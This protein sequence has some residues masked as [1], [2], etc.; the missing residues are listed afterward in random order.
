MSFS[1]HRPVLWLAAG[2]VLLVAAVPGLAQPS[3]GFKEVRKNADTYVQ[4][5]VRMMK[6]GRGTASKDELDLIAQWL[7]FR[8]TYP[9]AY[10]EKDPA[11]ATPNANGVVIMPLTDLV[12]AAQAYIPDYPKT[13]Q[14]FNEVQLQYRQEF[15]KRMVANLSEVLLHKVPIVRVNAARLLS[16]LAR[17]G[18]EELADVYVALLEKND[19]RCGDEIKYFAL[20]GLKTLLAIRPVPDK[21]TE[22]VITDKARFR[23]TIAALVKFIERKPAHT[24]DTPAE[25]IEG[26]RYVRREAIR[27]LAAAR[28]AVVRNNNVVESIPALVLLRVAVRDGFTPEPNLSERVEAVVGFCQMET[29]NDLEVDFAVYQVGQFIQDLAAY[30]KNGQEAVSLPWH[31]AG[32][33]LQVALEAWK[34]DV[35]ALPKARLGVRVGEMAERAIPDVLKELE[36]GTPNNVNPDPLKTWLQANKPKGDLLVRGVSTSK[37]QPGR[38]PDF[39]PPADEAKE[40]DKP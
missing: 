19:E 21:P 29:D 1:A 40:K 26:F 14:R 30:R 20:Q 38:T 32:A 13:P 25:E 37:I 5:H 15:N 36:S 22:T 35:A 12:R 4:E 10:G 27:A 31:I 8:M 24:A 2:G 9:K 17:S 16:H 3:T 6:E 39:A 23:K 18:W 7:V 28:N 33:K 11:D 34:K